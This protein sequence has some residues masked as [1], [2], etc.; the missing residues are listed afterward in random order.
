MNQL[1][2]F[3]HNL[4]NLY[5]LVLRDLCKRYVVFR[6]VNWGIRNLL[7]ELEKHISSVDGLANEIASYVHSDIYWKNNPEREILC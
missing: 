1:Q 2:V 7:L 6:N 5:T 4:P 3:K